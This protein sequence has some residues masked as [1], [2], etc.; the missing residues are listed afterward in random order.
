MVAASDI[1]KLAAGHN[2]ALVP[3]G[4]NPSSR[5]ASHRTMAAPFFNA[6]EG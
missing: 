2:I 5:A 4:G 6:V 3:Q 1:C